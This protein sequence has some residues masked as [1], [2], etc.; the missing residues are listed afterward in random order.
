[1]RAKKKPPREGDG[2]L[3]NRVDSMERL[4]AAATTTAG[5]AGLA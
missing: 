5:I 1:M 4:D 3:I 2:F